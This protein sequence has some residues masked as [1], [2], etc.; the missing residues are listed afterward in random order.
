[1]RAES[2]AAKGVQRVPDEVIISLYHG[3]LHKM[4]R[5]AM[6][7]SRWGFFPILPPMLNFL[8]QYA[9]NI[10]PRDCWMISWLRM[11]WK[12]K[13]RLCRGRRKSRRGEEIRVAKTRNVIAAYR[14]D[15]VARKTF[16][17]AHND[18]QDWQQ[19]KTVSLEFKPRA[20]TGTENGHVVLCRQL[21]NLSGP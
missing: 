12:V 8:H 3:G 4:T 21:Y 6:I 19:K 10:G 18:S 16:L 1:M 11:V 15:G 13:W 9:S 17:C 20:K 2:E 5:C 7:N 14:S